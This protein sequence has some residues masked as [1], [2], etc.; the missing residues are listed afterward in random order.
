MR[1]ASNTKNANQLEYG[2]TLVFGAPG[3]GKSVLLRDTMDDYERV[4]GQKYQTPFFPRIFVHALSGSRAFDDIP[5][6]VTLAKRFGIKDPLDIIRKVDKYGRNPIWM[7]WNKIKYV[8]RD[9]GDKIKEMHHALNNYFTNG[10]AIYDEWTVYVRD[11]PQGWQI[12]MATNRRNYGVEV[13]YVCHAL[14]IAPIRLINSGM[15]TKMIFFD[16]TEHLTQKDYD[17]FSRTDLIQDAYERV[18]AYPRVD[19]WVQYHTV[20]DFQKKKFEEWIPEQGQYRLVR[21]FTK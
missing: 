5:D 2:A 19:R 13:Y 12:D 14:R 11:K 21:N 9:E 10:L 1:R 18:R 8:C 16:T 15:F 6:L 4:Y 3:A 20:L 17:R 7:K